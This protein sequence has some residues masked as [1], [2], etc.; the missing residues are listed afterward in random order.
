ML[1]LLEKGGDISKEVVNACLPAL[2]AVVDSGR[3]Q[4]QM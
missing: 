4:V 1:K 2:V 3:Q